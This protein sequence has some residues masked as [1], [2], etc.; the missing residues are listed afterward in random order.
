MS[1]PGAIPAYSPAA[2]NG[3]PS[4]GVQSVAAL[5]G[6][7]QQDELQLQDWLSCV[8]AHT[9]KGQAAI[10]SLS[11]RIS[12]AKTRIAT[13]QATARGATRVEPGAPTPASGVSAPRSPSGSAPV[14]AAKVGVLDV[15]A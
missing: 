12:A 1:A 14:A 3:G 8:S 6:Q 15:W 11:A 7:V 5:A 4:F 2:G 10:R 13:L 9:P